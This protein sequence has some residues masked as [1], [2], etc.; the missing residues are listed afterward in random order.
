MK[1]LSMMMEQN[2]PLISE[3]SP[4][5]KNSPIP[6]NLQIPLDYQLPENSQFVQNLQ[7][8]KKS[9]FQLH[10]EVLY[11]NRTARFS[12]NKAN[13]AKK[14]QNNALS[15]KNDPKRPED[16]NMKQF[17]RNLW[18]IKCNFCDLRFRTD[19]EASNHLLAFHE[20][21][22]PT[23]E[24]I[25]VAL[26]YNRLNGHK[27]SEEPNKCGVCEHCAL[28]VTDLEG[29]VCV[30][31]SKSQVSKVHEGKMLADKKDL[32]CDTA[33]MDVLNLK[34]VVANHVFTELHDSVDKESVPNIVNSN[35]A[36]TNHNDKIHE[37][38]ERPESINSQANSQENSS[39]D[40]NQIVQTQNCENNS[41][42][43]HE[44]PT[45]K[46]FDCD[47]AR[48]SMKL[49]IFHMFCSNLIEFDGISVK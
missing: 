37:E 29:H 8:N 5:P 1:K 26:E 41:K 22:M 45:Y 33:S 49:L 11:G 31:Q 44:K 17:S 12:Q 15:D 28:F 34:E 2:P 3:N 36:V 4:I 18:G 20:E 24:S 40:N 48:E 43:H 35:Q 14:S 23:K 25:N 19:K 9:Q 6:T 21:K 27:V 47:Y 13:P 39:L 10:S 42:S 30:S 7:L 46:C 38:K 32:G 16:P